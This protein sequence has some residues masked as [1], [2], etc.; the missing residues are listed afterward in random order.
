[1]NIAPQKS[2]HTKGKL[3]TTAKPPH[4][5]G[6]NHAKKS[7]ITSLSYLPFSYV[8]DRPHFCRLQPKYAYTTN[9]LPYL[10]INNNISHFSKQG[11]FKK[12]FG[13]TI[14]FALTGIIAI[15][16]LMCGRPGFNLFTNAQSLCP[17][18]RAGSFVASTGL[19]PRSSPNDDAP[20]LTFGFISASVSSIRL[21]PA[22]PPLFPNSRFVGN[23]L[24]LKAQNKNTVFI[25]N[26]NND[27]HRISQTPD[28]RL[29]L[30]II[31]RSTV[32]FPDLQVP[33]GLR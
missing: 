27:H 2:K 24:A 21:L 33:I 10:D 32:L 29:S 14:A 18:S 13:I 17:L 30:L 6:S 4:G 31:I 25:R 12:M 5:P 7:L 9:E 11:L 22:L 20:V 8:A 15:P 26:N 16:N 1:M 3:L 19:L 23:I 28:T